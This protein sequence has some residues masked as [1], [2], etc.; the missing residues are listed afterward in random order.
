MAVRKLDGEID[1]EPHNVIG[2]IILI[3]VGANVV[4]GIFSRSMMNRLRWRTR[5]ILI[6]KYTHRY[7]GLALIALA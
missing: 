3:I 2:F 5:T 4:G 7:I 1:D 6:I